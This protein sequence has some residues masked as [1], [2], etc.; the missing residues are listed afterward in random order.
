MLISVIMLIANTLNVAFSYCFADCHYAECNDAKCHYG[1]HC[2]LL[3]VCPGWG[4][5]QEPLGYF[6]LFICHFTSE[7]HRLPY[8]IL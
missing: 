8:C 5:N 1:G 3:N 2:F 7:L 6:H 4:S